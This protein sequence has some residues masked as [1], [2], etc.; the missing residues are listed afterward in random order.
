[1][2]YSL[3]DHNEDPK[4][5]HYQPC[6]RQKFKVIEAPLEAKLRCVLNIYISETDY[7]KLRVNNSY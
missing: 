2:Y 7:S 1:M 4:I 3:G 6:V 5:F